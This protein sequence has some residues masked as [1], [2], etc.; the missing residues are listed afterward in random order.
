MAARKRPT[1]LAPIHPARYCSRIFS[2]ASSHIPVAAISPCHHGASTRSFMAY[3]PSRRIPRPDW[4]V[5]SARRAL[6][7][8]SASTVRSEVNAT[9]LG[10]TRRKFASRPQLTIVANSSS[11]DIREE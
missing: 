7:A 8:Q 3:V 4:R 9:P 6:L 10:T 5:I 11:S 1:K 2:T